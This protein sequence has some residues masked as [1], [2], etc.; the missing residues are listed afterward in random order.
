MSG[1]VEKRLRDL[2][3][4]CR[5]SGARVTHQRRE[6]LRAVVETDEHPDAQT[7]LRRVR[8]R[9]PTISFDTVYRTLAFLE[10]H[11]LIG[12]VHA[13]AERA[14]F[15]GKQTPHHHFICSRCGRILDFE[16]E[17]IDR[18]ELPK[19]VEQLGTPMSRQMQ[20]FGVCRD[21]T[22]KEE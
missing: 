18:V 20:V 14:R 13:S 6:V 21:C 3:S 16:S 1:S 4:A 10:T 2:E 12:R 11:G 8:A 5:R 17:E 19:R 15:D 22:S 9:M 7:V